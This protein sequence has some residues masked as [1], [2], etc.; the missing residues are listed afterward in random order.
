M[1]VAI[2]VPI[3]LGIA[4]WLVYRFG[5]RRGS[6]FSTLQQKDVHSASNDAETQQ[7]HF[8]RIFSMLRGSKDRPAELAVEEKTHELPTET[9]RQELAAGAWEAELEAPRPVYEMPTAAN[10]DATKR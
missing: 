2:V 9:N 10:D 1:P 5:K 7:G 8:E 3:L 4:I 6:A